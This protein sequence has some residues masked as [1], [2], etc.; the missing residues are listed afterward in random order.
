MSVYHSSPLN[1]QRV[2]TFK[3]TSLFH[4]NYEDYFKPSPLSG[5]ILQTTN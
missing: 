4:L 3:D 5:L 1:V 2:V